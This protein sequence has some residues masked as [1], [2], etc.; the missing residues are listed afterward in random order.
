MK[1]KASFW[2]DEISIHQAEYARR[3]RLAIHANWQVSFHVGWCNE[4]NAY[5]ALVVNIPDFG[6]RSIT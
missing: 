6:C 5:E 2:A 4:W 3:M 1:R